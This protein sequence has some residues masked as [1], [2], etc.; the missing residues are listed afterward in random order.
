[1]A[2]TKQ[3]EVLGFPTQAYAK[4]VSVQYT[5]TGIVDDRKVY[6]VYIG[7]RF[8]TNEEKAH[9]VETTNFRIQGVFFEDLTFPVFYG[10]LKLMP[11]FAGYEDA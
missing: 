10:V 11:E 8:Y 6:D 2:L 5:E 1:M 4:I 7:V 3:I 9:E